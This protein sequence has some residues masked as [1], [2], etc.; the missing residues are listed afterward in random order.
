MMHHRP[1][2][3]PPSPELHDLQ[4]A[5][6]GP[7]PPPLLRGVVC[8]AVLGL[9]LVKGTP[10]AMPGRGPHH[11]Q[12]VHWHLVAAWYARS[13]ALRRVNAQPRPRLLLLGL[14]WRLVVAMAWH[15]G[16]RSVWVVSRL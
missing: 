14:A 7:L 3:L 5:R 10:Q 12:P 9:L 16:Q 15:G 13:A 11:G 8:P 6:I 4:M 2:S 1:A